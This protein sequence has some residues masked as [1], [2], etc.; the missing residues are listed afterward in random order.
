MKPTFFARYTFS[1]MAYLVAMALLTSCVFA[2]SETVPVEPVPKHIETWKGTLDLGI[3]L[4]LGLK[5]YVDTDGK[6]SANLAIYTQQVLGNPVDFQRDGDKYKF[7]S[8][9]M[10]LSYD[11][12]LNAN[13][14]MLNGTFKQGA[15]TTDLVF[16]KADLNYDVKQNRPQ[17]PTAPFPYESTEVTFENKKDS[18]L[19]AGTLTT[20]KGNGPFPTAILISGSGP[21]DRDEEFLG[22]KTFLVIADHLTRQG[23]AVLRFDD[24][25]VGASKGEFASATSED[26]ADDVRSGIEFLKR[27]TKDIATWV[28]LV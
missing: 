4:E 11:A 1:V 17:T 21:Q 16:E 5:V 26:F 25:G 27:N 12:K 2:Q 13:K 3:K 23:I 28:F 9:A 18:I 22:H 14:S 7:S 24:R 6:L 10:G 15:L 19:L 20:P 8:K